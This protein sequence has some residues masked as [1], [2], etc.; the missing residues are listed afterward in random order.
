[1]RLAR[2]RGKPPEDSNLNTRQ[3]AV[4]RAALV[5]GLRPQ[6]LRA[7]GG[8]AGAAGPDGPG[9]EDMAV[10]RG[11]AAASAHAAA[12][13]TESLGIPPHLSLPP[14]DVRLQDYLMINSERS[15]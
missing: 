5:N 9:G 1:M 15:P 7:F 11:D 2:G 10:H 14:F 12:V 4:T 3:G 13:I 6:R 8:A